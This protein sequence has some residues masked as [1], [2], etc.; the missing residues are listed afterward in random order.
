MT[1]RLPVQKPPVRVGIGEVGIQT[2]SLG[3]VGQRLDLM[4]HL[5]VQDSSIEI[6]HRPFG[7][8]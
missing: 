4:F 8:Q 2:D 3:V 7:K 1:P 6:G 5:L